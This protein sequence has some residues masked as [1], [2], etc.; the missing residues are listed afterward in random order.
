MTCPGIQVKNFSVINAFLLIIKIK[1]NPVNVMN[2]QPIP[3]ESQSKFLPDYNSFYFNGERIDSTP[4]YKDVEL[5]M[6]DYQDY[7]DEIKSKLVQLQDD[8]NKS[9]NPDESPIT[10]ECPIDDVSIDDLINQIQNGEKPDFTVPEYIDPENPDTYDPS[11]DVISYCEETDQLNIVPMIQ[12]PDISLGNSYNPPPP[13]Q[14]FA[15][16]FNDDKLKNVATYIQNDLMNPEENVVKQFQ[17]EAIPE[18]FGNL[19]DD[20]KQKLAD[21]GILE[22]PDDDLNPDSIQAPIPPTIPTED[23]LK[24]KYNINFELGI[25]LAVFDSKNEIYLQIKNKKIEVTNLI[26]FNGNYLHIDE[27][28]DLINPSI[29]AFFTNGITHK[30]YYIKENTGEMFEDT[31]AIQKNLTIEYIG[32]DDKF[33]KHYCGLILDIQILTFQRA[34]LDSY[35]KNNYQFEI[36]A[37]ALYYYDWHK[38]RIEYNLVYPLPDL[39]PPVKMYSQGGYTNYILHTEKDPYHF[40]ELGFLTE[41]FCWRTFT[42]NDF[43]IAFW[44]NKIEYINGENSTDYKT[45]I[46]DEI[47]NYAV[48]YNDYEKKFKIKLGTFEKTFD[49]LIE[50]NLWYFCNFKY[51]SQEKK[52]YLNIR[53]INQ[54]D[55]D[56]FT[57]FIIDLDAENIDLQKFYLSSMLA[58]KSGTYFYDYFFCKFGTLALFNNKRETA[59]EVAQ[60]AKERLVILNL[61]L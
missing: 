38:D 58:S 57:E 32:I 3:L 18:S 14:N 9:L 10:Y 7:F 52:L 37:G 47:N 24:A 19:Y 2:D 30:L 17:Q 11:N 34:S 51:S 39:R 27:E 36:P 33:R 26:D 53:N 44:F 28:V 60:F 16:M 54:T 56:D 43:S 12:I 42:E 61:E 6:E 45:L 21:A 49:F 31:I 1:P 4:V 35:L 29:I 55:F 13:P 50:D 48:Q 59:E 8:V 46:F 25:P 40:M 20:I 15:C 5:L 22:N 23:L 41:F